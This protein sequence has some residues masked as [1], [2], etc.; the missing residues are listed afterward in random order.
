MSPKHIQEDIT[1]QIG[2]NNALK[3]RFFSYKRIKELDGQI[4]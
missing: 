3:P 1:I 4:G 2:L